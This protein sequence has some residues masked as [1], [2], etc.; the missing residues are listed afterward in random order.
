MNLLLDTQVLLWWLSDDDQLGSSARQAIEAPD[1]LCAVS[2]ASIWEIAIKAAL[3][4][5]DVPA[6]LEEILGREGFATLDVSTDHAWEVGRL[7]RLHRDPF[8]RMLVAQCRIEG[9]T[10][11][12]HDASLGGYAIPI[13]HA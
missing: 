4:K 8:D 12:T 3:G 6:G 11:V 13:L 10:L 2:A 9:L 1:N 5:L 7:P